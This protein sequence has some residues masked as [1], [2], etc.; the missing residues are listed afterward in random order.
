MSWAKPAVSI[1]IG[2]SPLANRDQVILTEADSDVI[3]CYM[4]ESEVN[5][6]HVDGTPKC[7][8]KKRTLK[9]SVCDKENIPV[10]ETSTVL[11][12]HHE[13]EASKPPA[14][15]MLLERDVT[16]LTMKKNS[17]TKATGKARS[18]RKQLALL[19][20]QRQLTSFFK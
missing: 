4:Y 9:Q 5:E 2:P 6:Q 17:K 19:Q 18:N 10:G 7:R 1:K 15:R 20:G 3:S 12:A 8:S 11:C 16:T 14:K 13:K